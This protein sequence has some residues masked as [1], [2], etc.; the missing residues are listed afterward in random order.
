MALTSNTKAFGID[1]AKI[2][3]I[4]VDNA[5]ALT[6]ETGIDVPGIQAI[7]MSPSYIEKDLKGDEKTLDYY[8]KL[9]SIEWNFTHAKVDLAVLEIIMGGTLASGGT[10]PASTETLSLKGADIPGYF[11]LEGQVKYTDA[12]DLHLVLYKCKANKV[13]IE[14]KN[15]EYAVISASG[16]AIPTIKDDKVWD[17]VINETAV[18][19]S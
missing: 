4:T 1:D 5:T 6:Y 14:F 13:D 9:E 3:G 19:I 15:E 16:K 18:A 2:S 17:I 12:G 10:A 7:G 8:T 11:K